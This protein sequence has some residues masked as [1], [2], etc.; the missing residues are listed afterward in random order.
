METALSKLTIDWTLAILFWYPEVRPGLR[1]DHGGKEREKRQS[2][3]GL[4]IRLSPYNQICPSL[5]ECPESSLNPEDISVFF[6]N[7]DV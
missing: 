7:Q 1:Q 4:H 2:S 6:R 5:I 3:R